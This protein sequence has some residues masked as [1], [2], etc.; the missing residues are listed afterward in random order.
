MTVVV[1]DKDDWIMT[2]KVID[3]CKQQLPR[4]Q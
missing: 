3:D 1:V 4:A 2:V